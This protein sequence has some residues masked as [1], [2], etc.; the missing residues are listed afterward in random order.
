MVLKTQGAFLLKT[1]RY[2]D[3]LRDSFPKDVDA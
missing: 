1:D 2:S 3:I